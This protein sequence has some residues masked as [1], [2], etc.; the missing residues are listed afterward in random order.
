MGITRQSAQRAVKI[1]GITGEAKDAARETGL[2]DNQSALL[3]VAAEGFG[4]GDGLI[5]GALRHTC[6]FGCIL[7]KTLITPTA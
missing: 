7:G 3:T 1:A 6:L 4:A 5:D 2:D